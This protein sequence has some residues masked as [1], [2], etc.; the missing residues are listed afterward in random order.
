[1]DISLL[2]IPL[3][4]VAGILSFLSPCVLPLVPVYLGHLAGTTANADRQRSVVLTHALAFIGGFSAIFIVLGALAGILSHIMPPGYK[5][6]I[7][8]IGGVILIILGLHVFGII[9]LPFLYQEKRLDLA[10]GR[11]AGYPTSFIVGMS[12]AAGWTPCIGPILGS[13]LGL[14]LVSSAQSI[15]LAALLLVF[16]SAG[17]A[18]PFLMAAAAWQ[19]LS[20]RIKSLYRHMQTVTRLSGVL[21][22]LMGIVLITGSLSMLNSQAGNN[23]VIVGLNDFVLNIESWLTDH[24]GSAG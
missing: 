7:G 20:L 4:F 22:V 9:R 15:A 8:Q 19:G 11:S 6:V 14:A 21:L 13:I 5:D 18:V 16:Y 10:R 17:L 24:I 3:A 2:S 12:F 23:V 1:M